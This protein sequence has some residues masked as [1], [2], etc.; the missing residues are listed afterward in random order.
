MIPEVILDM[1]VSQKVA[2]AV[3]AEAH[4][5]EVKEG[6]VYIASL[7]NADTP[8][9]VRTLDGDEKGKGTNLF[10]LNQHDR[11]RVAR[12]STQYAIESRRSAREQRIYE[13]QTGRKT[14]SYGD[15]RESF[16][17]RSVFLEE[18]GLVVTFSDRRFDAA[19]S[20]DLV[21]SALANEKVYSPSWTLIDALTEELKKQLNTESTGIAMT[22]LDSLSVA[23]D[24][25]M[26]VVVNCQ[27]VGPLNVGIYHVVAA[28][29]RGT[30]YSGLSSNTPYI[31]GAV[32]VKATK[33]IGEDS[34]RVIAVGGLRPGSK[35]RELIEK[36]ILA[37]P[38]L[39]IAL[40]NPLV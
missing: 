35:D 5:R 8:L 14:F 13:K 10:A 16:A 37:N 30:I 12:E 20:E 31:E 25:N 33:G 26:P 2:R 36:V 24:G 29:A 18:Q 9:A 40:L 6:L 3:V 38:S 23:E 17:G 15:H 22:T 32:P 27:A 21:I 1:G 34:T 7:Y 28:K 19:N 11:F 39:G 4:R